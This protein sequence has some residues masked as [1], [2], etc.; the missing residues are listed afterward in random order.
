MCIDKKELYSYKSL[1]QLAHK[2]SV[3]ILGSTYMKEMPVGELR[4]IFGI[5]SDIYNRS[6]TNLSIF[7]TVAIASDILNE[8]S[9]NKIILHLGET[10]L[11]SG[12]YTEEEVLTEFSDLL[13]YLRKLNKKLKI[14]VVSLNNLEN[15]ELQDSFNKRLE[16]LASKN[17]CIYAD[18]TSANDTKDDTSHIQSFRL[19]RYFMAD[20]CFLQII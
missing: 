5:I 1:N 2:N 15:K 9:P 12:R 14:V 4:Q 17:N 11:D 6:L 3:V 8:L 7:E 10:D 16:T 13:S 19:L 20:D 18:I